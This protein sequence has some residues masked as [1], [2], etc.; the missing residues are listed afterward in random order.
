M[1]IKLALALAAALLVSLT[2]WNVKSQ[3]PTPLRTWEYKVAL[4]SDPMAIQKE[5]NVLGTQGWVVAAID[6][7]NPIRPTRE[8]TIF[9][10]KRP[11]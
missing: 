7:T 2:A 4:I 3:S 6:N 10:L 9:Y 5:L 11:K 8:A 1:R